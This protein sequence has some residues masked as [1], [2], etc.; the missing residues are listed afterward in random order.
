M[1][2]TRPGPPPHG[3]E[4]TGN[5][6]DGFF[7]LGAEIRKN[8]RRSAVWHLLSSS[9]EDGKLPPFTTV[10]S[11]LEEKQKEIGELCF[12]YGITRLGVFGSAARESDFDATSSD[13]DF[14]ITFADPDQPGLARRFVRFAEE[15]ENLLA[16]SV[17][18]MTPASLEKSG[19]LKIISRDLEVLHESVS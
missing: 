8:Q 1:A 7:V 16:T 6:V 10:I 15:L 17:D 4:I 5:P 14:L 9:A 19:W 2:E 13:I 12:A 3:P 18:L 11:L